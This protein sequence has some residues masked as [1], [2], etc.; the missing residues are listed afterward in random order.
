V[1]VWKHL[2]IVAGVL[3]LVGLFS[4]LMQTYT[5]S[6]Y[7]AVTFDLTAYELTFGLEKAH[8]YLDRDLPFG[9]ERL[10]PPD[11]K[12]AR[13]DVRLVGEASRGAAGL[14]VPA[15]VLLLVGGIGLFYGRFGRALGA[16]SVLFGVL[17]VG[18]FFGLRYGIDYG[19][20]EAGLQ[21]TTVVTLSGSYVL[22]VIGL[23]GIAGGIGALVKPQLPRKRQPAGFAPPPMPPPPG[24]APHFPPPASPPA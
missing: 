21:H 14:F 18:A 13:S 23:L 4:P 6:K 11:I 9:A 10:I 8:K 1:K 24:P 3:G 2:V 19:M 17:S 15:L 16:L 7:G 20:K 5:K 12:S 22:L